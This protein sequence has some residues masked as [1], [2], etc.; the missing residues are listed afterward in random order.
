[1]LLPPFQFT[2]WQC[3]LLSTFQKEWKL[4]NVEIINLN[5]LFYPYWQA[6][7]VTCYDIYKTTFF[8]SLIAA[9]MLCPIPYRKFPKSSLLYMWDRL[10]RREY[11]HTHALTLHRTLCYWQIL[12]LMGFCWVDFGGSE[13]G[14]GKRIICNV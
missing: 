10:R 13:R 4:Q 9:Q 5:F 12:P 3:F 11:T 6:F 2:A 1:M 7:I 14:K 8:K